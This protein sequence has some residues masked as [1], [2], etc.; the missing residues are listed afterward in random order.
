MATKQATAN[1]LHENELAISH[2]PE[3]KNRTFYDDSNH[4]SNDWIM[5]R[6]AKENN[7]KNVNIDIP[8]NKLVVITGVS[9][10]GKSSLV[11]D[12]IF[13]EG[14]RR[15]LDSLSSYARQFLGNGDKPDV[16]SIEGL[17]PSISIDQKTSSHNPRST[18]GT[19]TEI[20]DYLRLIFARIGDAY[21][22]RCNVK[23]ESQTLKQIFDKIWDFDE[24]DKLEFYAPIALHEKGTFK[25]DFERLKKEGFIRVK[26]DN[27]QYL[28]DDTIEL[29]K[30][31]RHDVYVV[32]DRIVLHKD[33][34]TKSRIYDTLET[35]T[36]YGKG[37]ISVLR[38]KPD[39]TQ[40][41]YTYNQNASCSKCGFSL[42]EIEPRLFSFNSPVGACEYCKGLG[43]TYEPDPK[44]IFVHDEL[45]INEGGIDF[46][47][48]TVNTNI[49]DWQKFDAMLSYYHIDKNT[50]IRDL[51]EEAIEHILH[52]SDVPIEI[53]FTS[54]TGNQ[55]I[56][57]DYVEGVADLIQRRH[58]ETN[59]NMARE[60]YSKYLSEIDCKVCHGKKLNEKALAV[61][62][63]NK[64]IIELTDFPID[65]LIA[66]FKELKLS[67]YHHKIAKLALKEINDRL[68]FLNNVGLNYVTLSRSA[69]TLSGGELQRIRLATQIGSHLTGVLYV[70]DEPSIGLHQKDN[71]KLIETMKQIRDLGNSLLVVE[72]DEDTMRAADWLVDMGPGAG[73][74]GGYIVA[75]DTPENV[76]KDPYSLTGNYLA[77]NYTIPVPTSR[78]SGN[79]KK[80]ILKGAKG[81]NLKNI[82]VTFPLGKLIVVTGVSGSGKSTLI[83]ETLIKAIDKENFN[84]FVQ[85]LPYSSLVGAKDV[86]KLVVVDQ[87]PIGRT[88]RSNP[89]TYVGVFNDIRELFAQ[90]PEAKARGYTSSRFSFNTNSGICEKCGGNGEI[91]IEMNFLPD[92]YV[93]CDECNGRR[94]NEET[95]QIR[96]KGKN[97]YEVLDFTVDEA[98]EFFKNIPSISY[99]LNLMKDVGLGYMK[100]GTNALDLSGGEAQR[101]KL[102]KFLQRKPTGKTLYVLDEPTT[103]LHTHDIKNLIQILNRIV[104]N[105]DTVIVIEHN[106]DLIKVADHIIDLGPDGGKNGGQVIATGT[107]E[108]LVQNNLANSYTAQYLLP[109]L[110][111]DETKHD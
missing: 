34:D 63:N 71:D 13:N 109:Y 26:F 111:Q 52:G 74:N 76:M 94:Y 24:N 70:L 8:K 18:V 12:T 38:I 62:I 73:T 80:L 53:D 37:H 42:P 101:I 36:K 92:V 106:L 85:P 2:L 54:N 64:N 35:V 7:L 56:T 27:T 29:D 99:K 32:V 87:E 6:G 47:K 23:I 10:S 84:P 20:Y 82:N 88:P 41:Q 105:G 1:D 59:S 44:K 86:D 14:K 22:P 102:A 25:N 49:Y 28:L 19:V 97:I 93:K 69:N 17:S 21:C 77:H 16:D 108:Q 95:L 55:R 39:N 57:R 43:F 81:N 61:R 45:S 60:Y 15:Y 58:M 67:D 83:N 68:N 100:L 11:F 98:C 96:Y 75:S 104:N 91:K 33:Q 3:I 65:E 66:F 5:V 89:V 78:R 79:G 31:T 4:T 51:N 30:N 72:H 107:P 103:G 110:K 90:I 40:E 50:P 9:G 46:F 48:N